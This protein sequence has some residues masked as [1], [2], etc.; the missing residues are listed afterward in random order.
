[1]EL[2]VFV[3]SLLV[4]A[5]IVFIIGA[6]ITICSY[7]DLPLFISAAILCLSFILTT[8]LI[9]IN[10][11]IKKDNENFNI[12]DKVYVYSRNNEL[13]YV[14]PYTN[15]EKRLEDDTEFDEYKATT[16]HSYI[17]YTEAS[18]LCFKIKKENIYIN[19]SE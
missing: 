2:Y 5:L 16:E 13:F 1:M 4:F 10:Y 7:S 19:V 17:E 18:W 14:D 12:I 8:V 6:I 15:K 11:Y 3:I 9:S